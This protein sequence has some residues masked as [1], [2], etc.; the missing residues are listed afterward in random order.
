MNRTADIVDAL[1]APFEFPHVVGVGVWSD[2]DAQGQPENRT[3]QN[4][5]FIDETLSPIVNDF[6]AKSC[7]CRESKCSG[8][9]RCYLPQPPYPPPPAPAPPPG[10]HPSPSPS[11]SPGP[12]H[13]QP[14]A[15][16]A[17]MEKLAGPDVKSSFCNIP[18]CHDAAG[19]PSN[20][21]RCHECVQFHGAH[22][23]ALKG[24]G[25]T[26]DEAK[27]FC[28]AM[29]KPPAEAVAGAEVALGSGYTG[30]LFGDDSLCFCDEGYSGAD[31]SQHDADAPDE[32]HTAVKT[33][34]KD[35]VMC[36]DVSRKIISPA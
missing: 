11:P 8:H 3:Q 7:G 13:P 19:C 26:E 2:D 28:D 24:A 6:T 22:E 27:A 17:L 21:T 31:C 1:L 23:K 10:P 12:P 35:D 25:C 18:P 5:Q 15:C 4:Q 36:L 14:G 29:G 9:G 32:H 30:R 16:K 33:L 20:V 34:S